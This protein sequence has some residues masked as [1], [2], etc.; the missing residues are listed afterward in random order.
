MFDQFREKAFVP[1]YGD[2]DWWGDYLVAWP[3]SRLYPA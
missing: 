1:L 3:L 2:E